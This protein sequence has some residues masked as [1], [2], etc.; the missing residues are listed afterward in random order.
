[1]ATESPVFMDAL[2]A[3]ASGHLSMSDPAY[4]T[5]AIHAQSRA[6]QGLVTAIQTPV[7][8]I[9]WHETTAAASLTLLM[10][11]ISLG[12]TDTWYSHLQ[13]TENIIS[14]A[15]ALSPSGSALN[16]PEAFKQSAEGQWIL[17]HFAYHDILGAVTLRR[18]PLMDAA[19]LDGITGVVDS[20][21]GV[22]ADLLQLIA[23]VSCLDHDTCLTDAMGPEEMSSRKALFQ[24]TYPGLERSIRS[25]VCRTD[26]PPALAPVAYAYRSA[27]LV[28]F[29]RV[30]RNRTQW[31][32]QYSPDGEAARAQVLHFVEAEIQSAISQIIELA[33]AIP[34]GSFPETAMLFPLFMVGIET[35]SDYHKQV[36]RTRLLCFL[37][38]RRFQ[39]VSRALQLLERFWARR[40]AVGEEAR[41]MDW[42]DILDEFTMGEG[43]LLT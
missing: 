20:Y 24:E 39:N 27:T 37:E 1:M 10:S 13:G 40:E 36:I 14:S 5:T 41:G 4:S 6:L 34:V 25:W 7:P 31:P 12:D 33:G 32:S 11:A 42:T 21:L 38:L 23:R 16:G 17:R 8:E 30:V 29:Y 19:Y 2:F 22:G 26:A 28:Y 18:K 35:S 3:F 9:A 43:L 15:V